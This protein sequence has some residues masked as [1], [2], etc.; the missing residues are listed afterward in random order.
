VGGAGG[1]MP[2]GDIQT[3]FQGF[4]RPRQFSE[5]VCTDRFQ[6]FPDACKTYP[7]PFRSSTAPS[8]W[9]S[10]KGLAKDE[11]LVERFRSG[12]KNTSNSE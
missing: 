7:Q 8:V 3:K 2:M 4:V 1:N 9:R 6:S 10:T 5:A 11:Q 12:G